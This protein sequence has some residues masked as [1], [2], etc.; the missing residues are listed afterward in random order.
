MKSLLEI[1]VAVG[2]HVLIVV[3]ASIRGIGPLWAVCALLG[4]SLSVLV[5]GRIL[6]TPWKKERQDIIDSIRNRTVELHGKLT[7]PSDPKLFCS[8]SFSSSHKK[9]LRD[10]HGNVWCGACGKLFP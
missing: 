8:C 6:N 10:R 7:T 2:L 4:T 1:V 3:M 5:V 9:V